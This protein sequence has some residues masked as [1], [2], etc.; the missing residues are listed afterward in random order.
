MRL[1][2][3]SF[4]TGA[5][6]VVT[7]ASATYARSVHIP[8]SGVALEWLTRMGF[9]KQRPTSEP[10]VTEASIFSVNDE[11]ALVL[12]AALAILLAVAALIIALVAEY[13]REPTL[14]LSAV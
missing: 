5:T 8:G 9:V 4:F 11:N 13:R 2:L 14:Y 7:A 12:L 3:I 10:A 6:A 1:A